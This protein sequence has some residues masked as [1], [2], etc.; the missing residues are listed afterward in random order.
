MFIVL[1]QSEA[2]EQK[3]YSGEAVIRITD[4]GFIPQE[5]Y[6]IQGTKV[7]FINE[8]EIRRWPASDLHPTHTIYPAFDS[9][10]PISSGEKWSF[11]FEKI[12]TWSM[13]DHLSPY[14]T[15]RIFVQD[16]KP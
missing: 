10:K 11:V 9:G 16:N 1:K 12:G 4:D 5:I 6:I 8:S 15:G 2:P 3:V 14:I 7:D 13:H